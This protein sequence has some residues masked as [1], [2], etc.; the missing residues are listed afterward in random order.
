M[1]LGQPVALDS[2]TDDNLGRL[3]DPLC[4]VDTSQYHVSSV[5]DRP[6]ALRAFGLRL[7]LHVCFDTTSVSVYGA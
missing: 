1:L 7:K 5:R 6:N 3:P 4:E 2:L